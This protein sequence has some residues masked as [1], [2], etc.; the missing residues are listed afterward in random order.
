[1]RVRMERH[2]ET[3]N[4]KKNYIKNVEMLTQAVCGMFTQRT[5]SQTHV[6]RNKKGGKECVGCEWMTDCDVMQIRWIEVNI[7]Y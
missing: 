5:L 7:V 2:K 1:M 6:G 4:G 3:I